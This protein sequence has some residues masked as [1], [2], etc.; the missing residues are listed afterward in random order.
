GATQ[1]TALL[2]AVHRDLPGSGEFDNLVDRSLSLGGRF[3]HQW[4][5]HGWRLWGFLAGTD[6]SGSRKAL[7]TR[8]KS[9]IHYFQRPAATRAN[10]DTT[11]TGLA[12]REWRLELDRQN[13]SFTGGVWLAE[14][15]KGFEV[16]DIGFGTARER[17]DGGF[18]LGYLHIKPGRWLRDY[19]L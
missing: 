13:A 3:D 8:Q 14:I 16:N 7:T 4:D 10:L 11:L 6:V 2:T 18:K 12:G 5:D 17:L 1:V 9:S 15:S 19:N